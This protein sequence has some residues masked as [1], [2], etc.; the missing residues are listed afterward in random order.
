MARGW[1]YALIS[2]QYKEIIPARMKKK[3]T[4]RHFLSE[5]MLL[6]ASCCQIRLL[7]W[8]LLCDSNADL[9]CEEFSVCILIMWQINECT[10][11]WLSTFAHGCEDGV[12]FMRRVL[13]NWAPLAVTYFIMIKS[14]VAFGH[15]EPKQLMRMRDSTCGLIY[16]PLWIRSII[17]FSCFFSL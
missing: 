10:P 8:S 5:N 1:M 7:F 13:N 12:W 3:F 2:R 15:P 9:N 14:W 4:F 11:G 17:I 16:P 6:L